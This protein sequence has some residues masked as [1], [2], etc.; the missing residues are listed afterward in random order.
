MSTSKNYL[1][2]IR[3][4]PWFLNNDLKKDTFFIFFLVLDITC[5]SK[6]TKIYAL[7]IKH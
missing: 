6:K 4:F 7:N 5:P 2:D 3:C 1:N